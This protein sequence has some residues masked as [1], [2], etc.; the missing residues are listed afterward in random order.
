M[1]EYG[2]YYSDVM[3]DDPTY[4][5]TFRKFIFNYQQCCQYLYQMQIQQMQNYQSMQQSLGQPLYQVSGDVNFSMEEANRWQGKNK[6]E[7]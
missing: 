1:N 6:W 3:Q 7:G 5:Q 2:E 4:G